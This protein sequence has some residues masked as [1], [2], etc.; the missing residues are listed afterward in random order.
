M[1]S[2]GTAETLRMNVCVQVSGLQS[3]LV[4]RRPWDRVLPVTYEKGT[5]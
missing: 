1:Q 3:G 5:S 4:I 2:L